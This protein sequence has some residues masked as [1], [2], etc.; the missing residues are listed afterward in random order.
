MA[1]GPYAQDDF[2]DLVK[3]FHGSIAPGILLGGYMVASLQSQLPKDRL[4]DALCETPA[5]LPDA[6]QL[7][8]PCTMGN[9]WLRVVDLGRY[10]VTLYDKEDGQGRRA[11]VDTAKLAA[12]PAI[13]E[14]YYK[15]KPKKAQD[16]DRLLAEMKSAG[17]SLCSYQNVT[18]P[19]R[20]R[21]KD[22]RGA[23]TVCPICGEGY[24]ALHG[25]ICRGCQGEA[26]YEASS[27]QEGRTVC[28]SAPVVNTVALNHAVGLP[29]LHDLTQV[30]PGRS[31]GPVFR[32]GQV[33]EVGDICRLQRMGRQ[34][35]YVA[36]NPPP[37][38]DWIHE[39]EAAC[40]FAEAMAGDGIAHDGAPREGKI[41]FTARRDGLLIVDSVLLEAFNMVGG[42]MCAARQSFSVV[43][44]GR[45]LAAT[46][47][48]PLYLSTGQFTRAM[49]VLSGG[50]LFRV[51][52]MR[53]ARVGILVTGTEVFEKRV[54]DGFAPIIRHKVQRLGCRVVWQEIVPDDRAAIAG[55]VAA[56]RAA[57][58]DLLVTTAGLSVDP[59]DVTRQG[60]LDAGAEGLRYGAPVLP[61]AMLLLAQMGAVQIIGVPACALYHKA[62][63]FDLVLPRLLAGIAITRRD[64]ARLAEGGFCLG[65]KTCTFPKCGFG[66]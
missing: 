37:A 39:D 45:A 43:Q 65:C 38:S 54:V 13:A 57:G 19:S 64:L 47:A 10:A 9:G 4:H 28:L 53:R 26:P 5:C 58:A 33:I 66:K 24:P 16:K 22:S 7:L 49:A 63:S 23:M 51:K 59:D 34:R 17:A 1:I 30:E 29:L 56:A 36:Q 62:T 27:G 20:L 35:L 48:I 2:L 44:A 60:L 3:S 50:P 32:R 31:K 18:V 12:Y 41:T 21:G 25:A 46:R 15:R 11:F 42:V 52:P 55:A 40:A 14:W 6:V 61:G 8:T